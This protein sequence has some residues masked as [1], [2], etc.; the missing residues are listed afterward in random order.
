MKQITCR[1]VEAP[2]DVVRTR[3]FAIIL[4]DFLLALSLSSFYN[5]T[6][7]GLAL[8]VDG[9]KIKMGARSAVED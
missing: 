7:V 2:S 9:V 1:L 3:F 8:L 5:A 6:K 4:I